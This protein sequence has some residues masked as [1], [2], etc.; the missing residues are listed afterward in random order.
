MLE[1]SCIRSVQ[2][3]LAEDQQQKGDVLVLQ[4][5]TILIALSTEKVHTVYCMLYWR[6]C[7][8]SPYPSETN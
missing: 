5:W 6:Y 3:A 2:V 8:P 4:S 7:A 1:R